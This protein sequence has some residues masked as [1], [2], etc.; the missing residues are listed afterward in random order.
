MYGGVVGCLRKPHRQLPEVG[1]AVRASL[2]LWWTSGALRASVGVGE[3]TANLDT[4]RL[5][6]DAAPVHRPQ[7]VLGR[8]EFPRARV[9]L[10]N[11]GHSG[12]RVASESL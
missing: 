9:Y 4:E 7:A 2:M 11:D 12:F 5:D 10:M 3:R 6:V 8:L 1:G